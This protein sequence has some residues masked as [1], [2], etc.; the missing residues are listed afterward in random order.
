MFRVSHVL[1]RVPARLHLLKGSQ[2]VVGAVG[3]VSPEL[4]WPW[5]DL[6]R[7]ASRQLGRMTGLLLEDDV[8]AD[9]FFLWVWFHCAGLGIRLFLDRGPRRRRRAVVFEV[10]VLAVGRWRVHLGGGCLEGE[11]VRMA[12]G[13]HDDTDYNRSVRNGE[14]FKGA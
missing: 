5:H 11:R 8:A 13:R 1:I 10:A 14:M 2:R 12:M 7:M 9:R 4:R 6:L 3:Q